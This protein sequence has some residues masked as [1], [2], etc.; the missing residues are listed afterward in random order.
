MPGIVPERAS[1]A[2]TVVEQ[3]AEGVDR[4][5]RA[6]DQLVPDDDSVANSVLSDDS[7][8]TRWAGLIFGCC[9]VVLAP[10][11]VVIALTLP[12]RQLSP[13]YDIAWAGFDVILFLAVA[14]TAGTALRKSQHL[15]MAASWS[16]ALLTTD[17]WFDVMTAPAGQDR[18]EA[19]VMACLVELPLA[20]VCVW[21]ARHSHRLSERRLE[22]LLAQGG[23]SSP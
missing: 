9:A 22:I 8:I 1:S 10:W 16:S 13:N 2:E 19:I 23:K 20:A 6:V 21:L 7:R 14:S 4:V 5:A 3:A 15:T 11:I 18:I 12:S 17:A